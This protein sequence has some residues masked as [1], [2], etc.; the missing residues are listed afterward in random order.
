M[1]TTEIFCVLLGALLAG[2]GAI[3]RDY[4]LKEEQKERTAA[5]FYAEV[6][7]IMEACKF[8]NYETLIN[9]YI[10]K[11]KGGEPIPYGIPNSIDKNSAFK[12]YNELIE[13]IT[14][15]PQTTIENLLLFYGNLFAVLG[16]MQNAYANWESNKEIFIDKNLTD[17][18]KKDLELYCQAMVYGKKLQSDLKLCKKSRIPLFMRRNG[19]YARFN[20]KEVIDTR[21]GDVFSPIRDI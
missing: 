10:D 14:L 18:Y 20:D 17:I 13:N 2:G 7:Y 8:W 4:L 16:D 1:A 15:L 9:I 19:R 12:I 11:A 6:K 3:Y 21:T 5:A